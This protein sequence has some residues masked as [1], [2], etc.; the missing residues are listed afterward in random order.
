MTVHGVTH[1]YKY[2]APPDDLEWLRDTIIRHQLYFPLPRELNDPT[3]AR[4]LLEISADES[5]QFLFRQWCQENP[6][7]S[8][9]DAEEALE[10]IRE[11]IAL[12]GPD[13][14]YG[15]MINGLH[16]KY[17]RRRVF[18]LSKRWDNTSMWAKYAAD[19]RG[20]CL[21]FANAGL[22][23]AEYTREVEY[24]DAVTV[25]PTDESELGKFY[26][27]K[28]RDWSNE[29]E[30]RVLSPRNVSPIVTID[31]VLLTRIILGKDMTLDLRAQITQWA[32]ERNP[33]LAVQ[34]AEY[35]PSTQALRLVE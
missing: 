11:G 6:S 18:S 28:R 23:A 9:R 16:E 22:F 31:P 29:E 34:R 26:F 1:F 12:M 27:R 17:A 21:E 35:D 33:H 3:E 25:N 2:K 19:H 24:V 4:P 30:V 20:Y 32:Q 7:A 10:D 13:K 8:T 15:R 5:E 14:F